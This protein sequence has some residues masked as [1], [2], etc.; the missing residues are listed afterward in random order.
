MLRV[1]YMRG[2]LCEVWVGKAVGARATGAALAKMPE[3]LGA[4]T[5]GGGK[6]AA[7]NAMLSSVLLRAR[8]HEVRLVLVDP[9]QVELNHY[10]SI[11]H[12]LTPVVTNMKHA[13]AALQNI[14]REMETRYELMGTYR[15]RNL[16]E[17][18]RARKAK[19]H[20]PLPYILGVID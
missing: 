3:I 5:T 11:P 14:V 12:L 13:A 9:K 10:E 7:M 20:P 18:N 8:R 16:I 6:S 19:G 4:G 17:L 15:S 1:P 2:A